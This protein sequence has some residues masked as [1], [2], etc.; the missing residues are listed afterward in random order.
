MTM[1][2]TT[3]DLYDHYHQNLHVCEL[4]FRS[5]GRRKRFYGQCATVWTH[6]DHLPV[7]NALKAEGHGRVLVVDGGGSLKV[8]VLGDRIAGVAVQNNWAGIVLYGAVRDTCAINQLEIGVKAL[9]AT[10]RR[11]WNP[12][13]GVGNGV[14]NFGGAL[15]S[16]G[17]WVYADEDC[18]LVSPNE[19]DFELAGQTAAPL[20]ALEVVADLK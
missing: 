11:G 19:L 17:Q 14:I 12:V 15:F 10:A 7:L 18:V 1:M 9:G 3:A 6:E 13:S 5:F 8:G 2:G 16:P 20:A 4:Q